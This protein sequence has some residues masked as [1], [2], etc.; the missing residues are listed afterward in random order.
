MHFF[1]SR[2]LFVGSYGLGCFFVV[3]RLYGQVFGTQ[4]RNFYNNDEYEYCMHKIL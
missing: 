1:S 3:F 2:G 4:C